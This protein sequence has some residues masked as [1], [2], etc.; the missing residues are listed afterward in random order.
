MFGRRPFA[1]ICRHRGGSVRLPTGT[2]IYD[3]ARAWNGYTV[4]SPLGTQ[5]VVVIDMNGKVVKQWDGYVNSAG[6]PARILP[7]G[8]VMAASGTNPPHQES[9]RTHRA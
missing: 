5:A 3:P 9:A 4:L 2:T 7:D 1:C 8:V 6:G